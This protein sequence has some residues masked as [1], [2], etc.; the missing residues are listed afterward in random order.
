MSCID[1]YIARLAC[2]CDSEFDA[3]TA[4][5]DEEIED[6]LIRAAD[7]NVPIKRIDRVRHRHNFNRF[8]QVYFRILFEV[9]A[10]I[11]H[12]AVVRR[13]EPVVTRHHLT[14]VCSHNQL[15]TGSEGP[16]QRSFL[17]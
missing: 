15:E 3:N 5:T 17:Q 11:R 6:L 9:K 4:A 2:A 14:Y 10:G 12:K 13:L 16:T 1:L 7:R 8:Q